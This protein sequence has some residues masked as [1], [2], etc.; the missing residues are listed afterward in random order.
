MKARQEINDE[1]GIAVSLNN[2]GGV[3]EDLGDS[4]KALSYYHKGLELGKKNNDISAMTLTLNNLGFFYKNKKQYDKAIEYY[5]QCIKLQEQVDRTNSLANTLNN[6]GGAYFLKNDFKKA[7]EFCNKSLVLAKKTSSLDMIRRASSGLYKIYKKTNQPALALEM[8][9]LHYKMRDSIN[10]KENSEAVTKQQFKFEY[11]KKEAL[12]KSEQEKKD[13][14]TSNQTKRQNI[15]IVA[16]SIGFIFLMVFAFFIYRSSGQKHQANILL[17]QK[18]KEIEH[19]QKEI[20][21]SIHYAK[22]IQTALLPHEKYI[23]RKLDQLNK[24]KK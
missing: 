10:N 5:N 15:I 20:L 23:E 4:I 9:E 24:S 13:L 7:L 17:E 1:K 19:K 2:I 12:F 21:D 6:L 8:L 11:E 3:Y 22:R 14:I 18:N 16:G